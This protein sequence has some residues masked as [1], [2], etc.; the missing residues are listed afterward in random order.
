MAAIQ[1]LPV[2]I[3]KYLMCVHKGHMCICISNVKFS[4]VTLCQGQVCTDND[5][6]ANANA[7]TD[8]NNNRQSM[9][10][11][12]SLVNKPNEPKRTFIF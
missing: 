7:D 2:R 5:A 3:T 10:G 12:G 6:A 9:I 11:K 8:A 4:Y 1:K